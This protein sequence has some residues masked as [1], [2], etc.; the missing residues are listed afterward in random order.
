MTI[1]GNRSAGITAVI[2]PYN[3]VRATPPVMIIGEVLFAIFCIIGAHLFGDWVNF[4]YGF[5]F[6]PLMA[7]AACY[8]LQITLPII[9]VITAVLLLWGDVS[10]GILAAVMSAF[11]VFF[12]TAVG[13]GKHKSL[14]FWLI[15]LWALLHYYCM[16]VFPAKLLSSLEQHATEGIRRFFDTTRTFLLQ[17]DS[18]DETSLFHWLAT[19]MNMAESPFVYCVWFLIQGGM[20]AVIMRILLRRYYFSV[21]RPAVFSTWRVPETFIWCFLSGTALVMVYVVAGTILPDDAILKHTMIMHVF[22]FSVT[23]ML[24]AFCIY[25]VQGIAV[26]QILLARIHSI[27]SPLLM[28]LFLAVIFIVAS[29][30]VEASQLFIVFL[31]LLFAFGLFDIWFDFRGLDHNKE[32]KEH[33]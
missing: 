16:A 31:S 33:V 9:G 26:V 24:L 3:M 21:R 10:L 7:V 6:I 22:S 11:A 30:F 25:S 27:A 28:M 4:W 14:L 1:T 18:I 15:V 12:G 19:M 29:A 2:D 32:L 17:R 13:R 23:L 8:P 20:S 5:A